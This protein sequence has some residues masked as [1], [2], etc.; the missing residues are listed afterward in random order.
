MPGEERRLDPFTLE[1]LIAWL[2]KQPARKRY[3]FVAC[4]GTC[5]LDRY[6]ADIDGGRLGTVSDHIKTCGGGE[7]YYSI[8]ATSPWTF[9]AALT[10]ARKMQGKG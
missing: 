1:S 9:G 8:A 6:I 10:R 3:N 4:N 7:A 2:E 5:L